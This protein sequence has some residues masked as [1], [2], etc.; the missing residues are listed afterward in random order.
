MPLQP[1]DLIRKNYAGIDYAI[2]VVDSRCFRMNGETFTGLSAVAQRICGD[3]HDDARRACA[4]IHRFFG[5]E[6]D[7][8]GVRQQRPRD[9]AAQPQTAINQHLTD[10]LAAAQRTITN[11][12]NQLSSATNALQLARRQQVGASLVTTLQ[13][14]VRDLT[15][16][17]DEARAERDAIAEHLRSILGVLG[18]LRA[19]KSA[20]EFLADLLSSAKDRPTTVR[21]TAEGGIIPEN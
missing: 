4:A 11:L 13:Q 18:K 9:Q 1:G 3:N 8:C 20:D 21:F 7:W 2:H 12:R 15:T 16:E 17:R 19:D 14:Q 5:L 6:R 10:E